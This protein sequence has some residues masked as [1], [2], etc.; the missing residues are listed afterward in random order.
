MQNFNFD[1]ILMIQKQG[2]GISSANNEGRVVVVK[3][4]LRGVGGLDISQLGEILP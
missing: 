4:K 1:G 3:E 2:N